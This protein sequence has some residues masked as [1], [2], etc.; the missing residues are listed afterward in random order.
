M[1]IERGHLLPLREEGFDLAETRFLLVD[2]KGCV[3]VHTNF[4]STPLAPGVRARVKVGPAYVEV[5]EEAR[6]VARHE[7]RYGHC[8]Q[9]LNLEH[10]LNVLERKPGALAGSTPLK[11]W[12]EQGRWPESFD[13]LWRSLEQRHGRPAGT[14][15]MIELLQCGKQQ[16]WGRL[17]AAVEKALQ[18]GCT[19]AAAVRHLMNAPDLQHAAVE[20]IDAGALSGYARTLPVLTDYDRLLAAPVAEGCSAEVAP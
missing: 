7:R 5:Y 20:P 18:L 8:Q 11:Q 3:R 9:V 16:G 14:R 4:Y 19:D 2:G 6:C 10:Y 13:R 1:V 17:Q 15:E 12:R